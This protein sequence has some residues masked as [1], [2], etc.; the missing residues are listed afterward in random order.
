MDQL[1][2]ALIIS[3]ELLFGKV[4][5]EFVSMSWSN[6]FASDVFFGW[7]LVER[8]V[9][10]HSWKGKNAGDNLRILG[11]S[12]G[13]ARYYHTF[14]N[15]FRWSLPSIRAIMSLVSLCS[16]NMSLGTCQTHKVGVSEKVNGS[17]QL[18]GDCKVTGF[19]MGLRWV[20]NVFG[21]GLRWIYVGFTFT[22]ATFMVAWVQVCEV[23]FQ[24]LFVRT[25]DVGSNN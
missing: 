2:K 13:A 20:Y 25:P 6:T 5:G 8:M 9:Q 10:I 22:F 15:S 24:V 14:W 1:R 12:P 3:I 23:S 4:T 16:H 18:F 11:N 7:N 17:Y 19:T 21:M